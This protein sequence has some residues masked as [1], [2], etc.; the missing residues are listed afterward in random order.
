VRGDNAR[1]TGV[2]QRPIDL[3]KV[4]D[5]G[6]RRHREG[7]ALGQLLVELVGGNVDPLAQAALAHLDVQRHDADIVLLNDAGVQAGRAVG[8]EC[9]G[10]H[11]ASLVV[12]Q[13]IAEQRSY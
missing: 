3:D 13:S 4:P 11:R 9:Y 6:L 7:V 8:D 12:I 5:R 2:P 1:S 10:E